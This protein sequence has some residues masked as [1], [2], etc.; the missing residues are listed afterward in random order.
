MPVTKEFRCRGL[1]YFVA[2]NS[3]ALSLR[4]T[5]WRSPKSHEL[6]LKRVKAVII[7]RKSIVSFAAF[8]IISAITV[9]VT[10][11]DLLWFLIN[12]STNEQTILSSGALLAT[13]LFAVPTATRAVFVDVI[14]AAEGRPNSFLVRL[15]PAGQGKILSRRFR[16]WSTGD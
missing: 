14:I 15:V 1:N 6:P 4:R 9:V 3:E 13:I 7:Q 12:L 2:L 10:K 11:L 5:G 8:T 16:R